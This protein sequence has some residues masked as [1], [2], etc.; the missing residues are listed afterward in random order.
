MKTLDELRE[1]K[2]QF[3]VEFMKRHKD[4]VI[5]KVGEKVTAGQPT[6]VPSVVAGVKTK[7]DVSVL[8]TE[9]RLDLDSDIVYNIPDEQFDVQEVPEIRALAFW[10]EDIIPQIAEREIRVRPVK[11]G[12]SEG[13]YAITAGTGSLLVLDNEDQVLRLS[14]NH[15]YANSNEARIGDS[16]YQPG[17]HDGGDVDDKVGVL[18]G[19]WPIKFD[20]SE[21]EVDA[22]IRS[23]Q[24][25]ESITIEDVGV[26]TGMKDAVP[27]MSVWKSGRTTGVTRGV[28]DDIDVAIQVGYGGSKQA[29]FVDQI[30][31]TSTSGFSQGGD[32]GSAVF[33]LS[34]TELPWVGLLFAG[35]QDGR[36]T[37]VNHA[38]HVADILFVDLVIGDYVPEPPPPDNGG[39]IPG[40]PGGCIPSK[41]K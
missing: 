11:G 23:T 35:S 28:V 27:G 33:E 19:F 6:G 25:D 17:P 32:S 4:C 30:L 41:R 15:V 12:Y 31:V 26:P 10:E 20:G 5:L 3:Q 40:L 29:L 13:H 14:N 24:E 9:D 2:K 16:I 1:A 34:D 38:K 21:N 8:A 22:A 36:T 37:I 39:G 18:G 7:K